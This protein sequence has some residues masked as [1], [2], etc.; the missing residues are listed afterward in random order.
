MSTC[1]YCGSDRLTKPDDIP[2]INDNINW[3]WTAQEHVG[4]C[5]WVEERAFQHDNEDG[6]AKSALR[7]Y[8]YNTEKKE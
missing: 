7:N 8:R 2:A 4:G 3:Y 6:Y 1:A 5:R